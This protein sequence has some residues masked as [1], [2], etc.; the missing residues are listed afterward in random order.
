MLIYALKQVAE[1]RQRYVID[2]PAAAIKLLKPALL[3]MTRECFM[4]LSLD[5]RGK[6]VGPQLVSMGSLSASIVHP[7]EV[8]IEALKAHAAAIILGHNHPGGSAEPSP[9][10][11]AV[12]RKL[13]SVGEILGIPV[14]DHIIVAREGCVS[15]SDRG[16]LTTP[17]QQTYIRHE[18]PLEALGALSRVADGSS[19]T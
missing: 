7:R 6:T 13:V 18:G 3:E 15:F 11:L 10:D 19:D 1:P 9:E 5:T 8:F 4:I 2:G 16:L 17:H 12:T 14:L